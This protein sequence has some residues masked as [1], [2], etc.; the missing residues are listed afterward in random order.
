MD[1]SRAVVVAEDPTMDPLWGDEERIAERRAHKAQLR[2]V[3]RAEIAEI[4]VLYRYWDAEDLLLYV[5]ITGHLPGRSNTHRSNSAWMDFAA[6]ATFTRYP[7][8]D[9]A[10][11]AELAAIAAEKP[12]FN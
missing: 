2:A 5:G 7:S 10:R 6:R 11:T 9:A 8:R 12:V 3:R 4:T 1:D